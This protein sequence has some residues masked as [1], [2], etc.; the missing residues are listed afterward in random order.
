[1]A[2]T[3]RAVL[4]GFAC[5]LPEAAFFRSLSNSELE[6]MVG[7]DVVQ[8][9]VSDLPTGARAGRLLLSSATRDDLT[10][11]LSA[12]PIEMPVRVATRLDQHIMFALFRRWTE[13]H[14]W[15]VTMELLGPSHA[16]GLFLRK[17]VWLPENPQSGSHVSAA[18]AMSMIT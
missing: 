9:V 15:Q 8:M 10:V 2:I 18:E 4:G 5:S 14:P 12:G 13:C 7:S 16:E 3:R 17:Q 6:E 11:F 1:M